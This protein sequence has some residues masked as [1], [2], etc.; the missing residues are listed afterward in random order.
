[1]PQLADPVNV[2]AID[3]TFDVLYDEDDASLHVTLTTLDSGSGVPTLVAEFVGVL[4]LQDAR[5]C[6]RQLFMPAI[7]D[8][9]SILTV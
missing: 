6:L 1:M 3:T 9:L 8:G 2:R 4:D 7:A 5:S